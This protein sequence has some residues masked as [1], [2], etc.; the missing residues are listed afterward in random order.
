[1]MSVLCARVR[2]SAVSQRQTSRPGGG[3]SRNHCCVFLPSCEV[4]CHPEL[5]ARV[6]SSVCLRVAQELPAGCFG[7]G[8]LTLD[9]VG[10]C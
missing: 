8:W 2:A 5:E 6:V 9:N 1:M 3:C 7:A 10:W 4:G